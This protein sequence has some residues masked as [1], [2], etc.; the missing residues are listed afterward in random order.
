MYRSSGETNAKKRRTNPKDY[1]E[2]LRR[3]AALEEDKLKG[4]I[5]SKQRRNIF[6]ISIRYHRD[7]A[8]C[9]Q[10]E[11]FSVEADVIVAPSV[12]VSTPLP[13]L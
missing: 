7:R 9:G 10:H 11:V 3:V 6:C 13:V 5:S 4:E 8:D 2:D 1:L 12:G